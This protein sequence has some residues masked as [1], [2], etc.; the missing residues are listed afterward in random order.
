MRHKPTG[1]TAKS[2]DRCQH[3]NRRLA[4]EILEYRVQQH[5]DDL[6]RQQLTQER[7]DK[8]GSG[9]RADKIRTYREQDDIVVDDRTSRKVSLKKVR[10]GSLEILF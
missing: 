8:A 5:F 1:I 4:R 7:R 2:A 3:Q 10:S 6:D 9:Q